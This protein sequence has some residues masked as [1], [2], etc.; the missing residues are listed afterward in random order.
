MKLLH[1]KTN[2][3]NKHFSLKTATKEDSVASF[4]MQARLRSSYSNTGQQTQNDP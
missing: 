2:K 3:Q 1:E 4:L